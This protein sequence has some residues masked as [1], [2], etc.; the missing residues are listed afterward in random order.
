MRRTSCAS[1]TPRGALCITR[2]KINTST[3]APAGSYCLDAAG[4]GCFPPQA[5]SAITAARHSSTAAEV[6]PV[7]GGPARQPFQLNPAGASGCAVPRGSADGKKTTVRRTGSNPQSNGRR[8]NY[9][10]KV[11][12]LSLVVNSWQLGS[13]LS[14]GLRPSVRRPV[15]RTAFSAFNG[16][17]RCASLCPGLLGCRDRSHAA[18]RIKVDAEH[19]AR[20]PAPL[21]ELSL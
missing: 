13:V 8:D 5:A 4:A 18:I 12:F 19:P 16:P 9:P 14:P 17:L 20:L 21:L 2:Y 15:V 7:S 11:V 6:L 3:A 10:S 1:Y